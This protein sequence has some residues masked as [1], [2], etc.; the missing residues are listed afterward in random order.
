MQEYTTHF[1]VYSWILLGAINHA[2][3]MNVP[4]IPLIPLQ[5]ATQISEYIDVVFENIVNETS[6][7]GHNN[8]VTLDV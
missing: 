3:V 8:R 4:V 2:T 7:V 6:E 1:R 5:K